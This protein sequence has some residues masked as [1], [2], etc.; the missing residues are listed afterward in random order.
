METNG[1][2]NVAPQ[3]A[4]LVLPGNLLEVKFSDPLNQKPWEWDLVICVL[5]S[6]LKYRKH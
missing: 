6:M 5:T 4:A 2:Q 1:S 3:S